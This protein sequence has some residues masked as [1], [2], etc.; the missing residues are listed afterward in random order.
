MGWAGVGLGSRLCVAGSQGLVSF[1]SL[2]TGAVAAAAT[3]N[4]AM[5]AITAA[6]NT[7]ATRLPP[8]M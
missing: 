4:T 8:Q 7:A 1:G 6:T 2:P 5:T 3:T